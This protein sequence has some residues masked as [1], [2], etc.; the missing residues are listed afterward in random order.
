MK[1]L[2]TTL[3]GTSS[4]QT[5]LFAFGSGVTLGVGDKVM[6]AFGDRGNYTYDHVNFNAWLTVPA[7]GAIALL[8]AAGLVGASRRR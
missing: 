6:I 1:K 7:P 4:D 8:A 3:A 2:T 5:D